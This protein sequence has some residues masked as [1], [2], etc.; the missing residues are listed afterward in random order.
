M[1]EVSKNSLPNFGQ[2]ALQRD[3]KIAEKN[4][5]TVLLGFSFCTLVFIPFENLFS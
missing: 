4:L 1:P 5:F 2:R 3:K